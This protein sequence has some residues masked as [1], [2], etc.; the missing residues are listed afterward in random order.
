VWGKIKSGIKKAGNAVAKAVNKAADAVADIVETIGNGIGDGLTWL[1]EK[2]PDG[3]VLGWLGDVISGVMTVLAGL[4]KALGAI[5]GGLLSGIIKIVGGIVTLD[6]DGILEGFGD[7]GS[8]I[9]GGVIALGGAAIALVQVIFTV[10]R[11]RALNRAE[12]QLVDLV[13]Q[14]SIATYN[15]RVVDGYAGVFSLNARPFVLGNTIYMKGY[16]AATDPAT[17]VHE[18]VHVWQNQHAG[19]R[20][21]AEALAS[22][23]WGVKYDW[24]A[25]ANAAK[26]WDYFER[27]AQGEFVESVFRSGGVAHGVTGKGAFFAENNEAL[28]V[29]RSPTTSKDW[30]A[31][32]NAATRT[33]RDATPWRVT[34]LG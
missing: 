7:I 34:G 20:Y 33:I 28:R 8:G 9:A 4:V 6:L 1:S 16:S 15:V 32:A 31:L 29:F 14:D 30:T 26:D 5:V 19:S 25:E 27:E 23:W 24:E 12:H 18:C 13:F 2:I 10:G 3:G 17:F 22:Q 21:A 11:P